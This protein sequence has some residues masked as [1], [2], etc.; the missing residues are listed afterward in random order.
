VSSDDWASIS[1]FY[2]CWV[3]IHFH[4]INGLSLSMAYML[5]IS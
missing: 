1:V 5:L 3:L 4:A 2:V